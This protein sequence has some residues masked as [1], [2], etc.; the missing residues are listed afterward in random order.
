MSQTIRTLYELVNKLTMAMAESRVITKLDALD[1]RK[2][3]LYFVNTFAFKLHLGKELFLR[4]L[5]Y[6]KLKQDFL[7]VV[8]VFCQRELTFSRLR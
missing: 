8:F 3:D 2:S 5:R 1:A 7:I 4:V 6:Q